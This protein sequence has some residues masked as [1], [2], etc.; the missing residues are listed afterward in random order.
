MLA[1]VEHT[2]GVAPLSADD[3]NA[4]DFSNSFDYTQ[5]PLPGIR[6]HE[7]RVPRW[8][9]RVIAAHPDDPDDPT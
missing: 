4:Y 6:L 1:Y 9:H 2:F 8:E 5:P 3:A 7:K